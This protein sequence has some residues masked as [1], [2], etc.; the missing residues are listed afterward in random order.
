MARREIGK[1]LVDDA[2]SDKQAYLETAK[3]LKDTTKLV[4]MA[5]RYAKELIAYFESNGFKVIT[6]RSQTSLPIIADS[7]IDLLIEAIDNTP[8][9][10]VETMLNTIE[11]KTTVESN[12]TVTIWNIADAIFDVALEELGLKQMAD[13]IIFTFYDLVNIYVNYSRGTG[14]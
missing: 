6:G 4:Q 8:I 12:D 2:Q 11:L 3:M 14:V 5:R 13:S 9:E 1:I 7:E 10:G